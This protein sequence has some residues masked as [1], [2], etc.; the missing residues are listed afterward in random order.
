VDIYAAQDNSHLS[1]KQAAQ[2]HIAAL[3]QLAMLTELASD[4]HAAR[5]TYQ[6]G[7]P[8]CDQAH[9]RSGRMRELL[10]EGLDRLGTAG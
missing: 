9:I 7:I 8:L 10:A 3:E 1:D 4:L 2:Q 6:H 5:H